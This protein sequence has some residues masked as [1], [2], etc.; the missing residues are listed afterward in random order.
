MAI[1]PLGIIEILIIYIVHLILKIIK[2]F[3]FKYIKKRQIVIIFY[4]KRNITLKAFEC[5]TKNLT[6][7]T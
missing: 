6:E 3:F 4:Y 5:E 1:R 2:Y 7:L